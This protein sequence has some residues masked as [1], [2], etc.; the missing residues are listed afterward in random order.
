MPAVVP[1]LLVVDLPAPKTAGPE[2]VRALRRRY[3]DATVLALSARF[4]FPASAGASVARQ[5]GAECVMAKP[6]DLAALVAAARR[7]LA[8]RPR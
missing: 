4:D 6:L 8:G 1:R 5:M 7:L 3:P 2:A